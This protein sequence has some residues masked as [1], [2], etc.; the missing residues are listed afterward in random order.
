MADRFGNTRATRAPQDGTK[1]MTLPDRTVTAGEVTFG[2]DGDREAFG[3]SSDSSRMRYF[4]ASHEASVMP[5][6]PRASAPVTPSAE[7][8]RFGDMWLA[9]ES[10]QFPD[11]ERVP[12]ALRGI[13]DAFDALG[14]ARGGVFIDAPHDSRLDPTAWFQT[15]EGSYHRLRRNGSLLEYSVADSQVL[16]D[17]SDWATKGKVRI[18]DATFLYDPE[19]QRVDFFPVSTIGNDSL[20]LKLGA[21]PFDL[22]T[23]GYA[24]RYRSVFGDETRGSATLDTWE[25]LSTGSVLSHLQMR[26]ESLLCDLYLRTTPGASNV[27]GLKTTFDGER[28]SRSLDAQYGQIFDPARG[29]GT[30]PSECGV[31]RFNAHRSLRSGGVMDFFLGGSYYDDKLSRP[32]WSFGVQA[33]ANW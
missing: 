13:N 9:A 17:F 21:N 19:R 31:L 30:P 27:V 2:L 24:H 10:L 3:F 22:S 12:D 14:I 7:P 26:R 32:L 18:A 4:A 16:G 29:V 6:L 20:S 25:Q 1:E 5:L 15:D 11:V 8:S 23:E 33:E 28:V